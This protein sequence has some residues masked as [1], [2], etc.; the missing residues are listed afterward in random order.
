MQLVI[1]INDKIKFESFYNFLK[2]LDFIK[3]VNKKKENKNYTNWKDDFASIG[4]WD[5]N[6][7]DIKL[8]NWKID[9]F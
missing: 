3:I 2:N 6:E 4:V 5:L 8:Q 9:E 7:N 1:E